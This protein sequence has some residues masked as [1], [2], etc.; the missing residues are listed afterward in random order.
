MCHTCILFILDK[1]K[2]YYIMSFLQFYINFKVDVF[3]NAV[4]AAL[5]SEDLILILVPLKCD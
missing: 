3:S 2:A 5:N 4:S 1:D